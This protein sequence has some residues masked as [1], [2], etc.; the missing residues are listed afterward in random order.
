MQKVYKKI[1]LDHDKKCYTRCIT[2][3]YIHRLKCLYHLLLYHKTS[4]MSMKLVHP[5]ALA[6][7]VKESPLKRA[8][9]VNA[10]HVECASK[11]VV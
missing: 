10:E 8:E 9:D 5:A 7:S 6:I 11:V 4:Q 3:L 1:N 2:K